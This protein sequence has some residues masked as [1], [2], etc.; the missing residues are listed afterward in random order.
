M[1]GQALLLVGGGGSGGSLWGRCQGPVGALG[2]KKNRDLPVFRAESVPQ[3]ACTEASV[4][5]R[6]LARGDLFC[7]HDVCSFLRGGCWVEG[8]MQP[9]RVTFVLVCWCGSVST[10]P[11][12][13]PTH[14]C[15]SCPPVQVSMLVVCKC[16]VLV[17]AWSPVC[18]CL[19]VCNC[20]FVWVP[21]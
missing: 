21:L 8:A 18:K 3:A 19:Y 2:F 5:T 13:F 11:P 10:T 16:L 6:S 14:F 1:E 9:W 15:G 12:H 20:G 4:W 17:R 7:V